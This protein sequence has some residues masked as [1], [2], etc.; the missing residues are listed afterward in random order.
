MSSASRRGAR[1]RSELCAEYTAG[2]GVEL[3]RAAEKRDPER[4]GRPER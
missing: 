1:A 4:R 3:T 2:G